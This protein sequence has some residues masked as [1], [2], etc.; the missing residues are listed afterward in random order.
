MHELGL[1]MIQQTFTHLNTAIFSETC[2]PN[3][4]KNLRGDWPNER[5][6]LICFIIQTRYSLLKRG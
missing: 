1:L 4:N 2:G 3:Y 6:L 5:T